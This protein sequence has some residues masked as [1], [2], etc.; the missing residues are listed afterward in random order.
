MSPR[1]RRLVVT[2]IVLGLAAGVVLV[3]IF[4]PESTTG[5]NG[6]P[7]GAET[8]T[9]AAGDP[10]PQPETQPLPPPQNAPPSV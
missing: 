3:S 4:G 8:A 6:A 2:T 9:A 1:I 7:P 5:E 10:T